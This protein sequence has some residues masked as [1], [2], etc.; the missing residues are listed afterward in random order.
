M[1][2]RFVS[3]G[4]LCLVLPGCANS[5]N[6]EPP[7]TTAPTGRS[8]EPGAA[9]TRPA[10]LALRQDDRRGGAP[11]T[12]PATTRAAESGEAS[13]PTRPEF[14]T[15]VERFEALQS[16]RVTGGV[17]GGRVVLETDNVR[18]LR[19]DRRKLP[20]ARSRSVPLLLDGQGIEMT[21]KSDVVELVRTRNGQWTPVGK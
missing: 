21:G 18:V 1:V 8:E 12:Q 4:L 16:A 5:R 9:A 7:I 15:I 3:A 13:R 11:A 14:V 20:F 6:A 10:A 17:S 2:H 19:I